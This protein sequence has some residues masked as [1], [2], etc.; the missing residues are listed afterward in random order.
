MEYTISQQYEIDTGIY[1]G[2]VY[3]ECFYNIIYV[4]GNIYKR[5][6]KHTRSMILVVTIVLRGT[7]LHRA[8][9]KRRAR[10]FPARLRH[11]GGER[12]SDVQHLQSFTAQRETSRH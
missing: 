9:Q 5:E 7:G 3:R 6:E 2:S 8:R 10:H 1:V 12:A 11:S 4:I